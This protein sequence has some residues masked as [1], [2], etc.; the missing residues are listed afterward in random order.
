M[1]GAAGK[2]VAETKEH[3]VLLQPS[4]ANSKPQA[5][6]AEG[7]PEQPDKGD[8]ALRQVRQFWRLFRICVGSPGE[9]M[10]CNQYSLSPCV[11]ERPRTPDR[12]VLIVLQ[13]TGAGQPAHA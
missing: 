4:L 1:N 12:V 10:V 9:V 13:D 5:G 8:V 7:V 6:M 2:L 3:N 11:A